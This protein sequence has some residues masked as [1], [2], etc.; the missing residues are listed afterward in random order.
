MNQTITSNITLF[1]LHVFIVVLRKSI[2]MP[3]TSVLFLL[4]LIQSLTS[5]ATVYNLVIQTKNGPVSGS[6]IKTSLNP[7]VRAWFSIPFAEP[8]VG[9]LRFKAPLPLQRKWNEALKT[10][11][12]PNSCVQILYGSISVCCCT[13]WTFSK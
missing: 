1:N 4:I 6:T 3:R 10:I 7:T 12:K 9:E 11:N 13:R 8:P 2:E 5:N